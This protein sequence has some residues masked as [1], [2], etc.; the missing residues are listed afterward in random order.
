[1]RNS[2]IATIGLLLCL[3]P[4]RADA[5]WTFTDVTATAQINHTHGYSGGTETD[6]RAFCTGVAAGD[7][8]NDGW[9]DLFA[10]RGDAGPN[11]LYRN[12]GDGTFEE[13]ATTAEVDDTMMGCGATFADFDGDGWLDLLVTA[14][15]SDSSKFYKND[16]D[17][18]FTDVSA[19]F[20]LTRANNVSSAFADYDRDGDLDAFVTHWTAPKISH[21]PVD[22]H[23]WRN[24]G[25]GTFT[26]VGL[27]AGIVAH[28]INADTDKTFTPNFV[29]MDR[30]GWLDILIASDFADSQVF[31]NN[32]D[33][34]FTN[35]TDP[36]II[37]DQNGMGATVCDYDFDGDF[38][39]FVTSI[40]NLSKGRNGN[41]FYRNIG[42]QGLTF[43]EHTDPTGT[44]IG[45]WGWG[46]SC[47]DLDNDGDED[48]FH[49]N[50]FSQGLSLNPGDE[51]DPAL[52]YVSD[53]AG[54]FTDEAAL[55]GIADTGRGLG[56]V[57]FD[58]DRDGDLDIFIANNQAAP[59]LYRNDGLT[60]NYLTVKLQ[61][62]TPNTQA[63][64]SRVIATVGGTTMSR[65]MRAGSNYVSQDPAE[66]HF[67]LGSSTIVDELEIQWF[68]GGT[69]TMTNVS[70]NQVLT[71][72]EPA[73]TCGDGTLDAGE[74]CDLGALNGG[75][76]CCQVDCRI[77]LNGATCRGAADICDVAEV[78]DGV[79]TSCPADSFEVSGTE[80]R[81]VADVCDVAEQC[82]GSSAACP[83][84]TFEPDT[85]ECRSSVGACDLAETCSGTS[86][87]CPADGKSTS[88]CRPAAGLCDLPEFC[89]GASD[90]CPV[91]EFEIPG[92]ECR[93]S[94]GVCD[95][96]EACTGSA[97]CPAD[98]KSSA[99]CRSAA[100]ICDI[101]ESCDGINDDCPADA[102]EPVSTVCRGAAGICDVDETCDGISVDCP[103]DVLVGAGTECR[104]ASGQCDVAEACT[105]SDPACPTNGFASAGTECR[106]PT[107]ACDAAEVCPG[108]APSCPTDVVVGAGT[109]CRAVAGVCDVAEACDGL[110]KACPADGFVGASTV[111]RASGGEC[112]FEETCTGSG[113][114]CP[115]DQKSTAECRASGGVCDPAEV[116]DGV[117]DTC[118]ADILDATTECR[119]ATGVCDVGETCNGVDPACPADLLEPSGTV[120]RASV[121]PC[122]IEEQCDGF[123][124]DCP[125]DTGLP[126]S[127]SDGA[128]DGEDVCPN[129]PDPAQLDQDFDTIGDACDACTALQAST[130]TKPNLKI[131]ALHKGVGE[132]RLKFKGEVTL[133]AP[134]DPA[135][136]AVTHGVRFVLFTDG[137]Q[138][139]PILDITVPGGVYDPETRQG[140][141]ASGSGLAFTFKSREGVD[142]ITKIR[143][144]AKD[145]D[146]G[147][148]QFLVVGKDGDFPLI[149]GNLPLAATLTINNVDGQCAELVF[150]NPPTENP[151]C[152]FKSG[153][154]KLICK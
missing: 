9:V 41:R 42:G 44:R 66:A 58:Y 122:D 37:T 59:K 106:A 26:D 11:L 46:A 50:G 103:A 92:V 5:V 113:A 61:G 138:R 12:K 45:H 127:D 150:E 49:V 94:A 72:V 108:N 90:N 14:F 17:G 136:D 120:C 105:G 71:V 77:R 115:S 25:D 13:V 47:Q 119:P 153:D 132:Q 141:I 131:T 148:V 19:D 15:E 76:S 43:E 82:T 36:L 125:A 68:M 27:A 152:T 140:W 149:P 142:G 112:D 137:D 128:C 135:L 48:I 98:A 104:A 64:G 2:L 87:E 10:I 55:R 52:L 107:D 20:P 144:K 3:A 145:P 143:L 7:Y 102:L 60:Q 8:D 118:P 74:E 56:V 147:L 114:L 70:A 57:S 110:S 31:L 62:L 75:V 91:D 146:N 133:P 109:E 121:A 86:A 97:A 89:D 16:G 126:D 95:L 30:D 35:V 53:G 117:T 51:I 139:N 116:C 28:P 21:R 32:G 111:C 80:C 22:E 73:N 38:D 54:S 40:Y 99:V 24:N 4:S 93:A 33:G 129:T 85:V 63:I 100:G 1:M 83:A 96:P 101:T 29:D 134:L 124:V 67:G 34:S 6:E 79:S 65:L 69:T 84:D 78:C 23:L 39:W 88:E 154:T 130:V 123:V 18:T 81:A 151:T